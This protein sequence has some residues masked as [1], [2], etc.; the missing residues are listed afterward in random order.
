MLIDKALAKKKSQEQ[1]TSNESTKEKNEEESTTETTTQTIAQKNEI[2]D[3]AVLNATLTPPLQNYIPSTSS[4]STIGKLSLNASNQ[5]VTITG[6]TFSIESM[7]NRD[8]ISYITLRDERNLR[9]SN[10]KVFN[11]VME[12]TLHF[13]TPL[14]IEPGKKRE[15]QIVIGTQNFHGEIIE[16]SIRH[17]K[18][19]HTVQDISINGSLKQDYTNQKEQEEAIDQNI[20]IRNTSHEQIIVP[21]QETSLASFEFKC[22]YDSCEIKE[23]TFINLEA[24]SPETIATQA[25][26]AVTAANGAVITLYREGKKVTTTSIVDGIVSFNFRYPLLLPRNEERTLHMTIQAK[27]INDASQS[28]SPISLALLKPGERYNETYQTRI[29]S[30]ANGKELGGDDYL[31][32]QSKNAT[33]YIR[34]AEVIINPVSQNSTFLGNNQ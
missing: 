19:I 14:V 13:I 25:S 30:Q 2:L 22:L 3:K 6:I 11:N 31:T 27:K 29:L 12:A 33:Q 32:A 7:T 10:Q 17:S 1:N 4:A 16:L 20:K 18:H 28:N 21:E 23:L 8:S 34:K 24:D 5:A 15:L 26:D 9:I